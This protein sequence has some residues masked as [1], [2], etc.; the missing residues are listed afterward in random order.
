MTPER[1]RELARLQARILR[2]AAT[3][4]KPGG[5]LVYSVCTIS[6]AEGE[7]VIEAFLGEY[8]DFTAQERRQLLPHR[9]GTDGFFI[10]KLVRV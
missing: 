3:A 1:V 10:A 2:A 9:E 4:T 5:T 7:D 8:P 6:R